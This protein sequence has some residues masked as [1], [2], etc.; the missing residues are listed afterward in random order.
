M[1]HVISQSREETW[2]VVDEEGG[3]ELLSWVNE[4]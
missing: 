4:G 3:R 2:L 1:G